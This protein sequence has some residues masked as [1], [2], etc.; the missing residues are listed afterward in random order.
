MEDQPTNAETPSDKP[1]ENPAPSSEPQKVENQEQKP[2]SEEEKKKEDLRKK[3]MELAVKF[4]EK[5]LEKY[6]DF[7][8]SVVVFGSLIRGDFHDK[9]DID[10]LVIIDDTVA[11]FSPEVKMQFDED[12]F[13]IGKELSELI[14]V[15]PAWTLTEFWDMARIGHPLLYTIVRDG[16]ALHDT[17]FWIPVRKLLE[18]GKIPSTIEAIEKLMESA[19]VRISKVETT[20]LYLIAEDLYYALLNS[21][22]GVLMYMGVNAPSPK[23]TSMAMKEHLV[24][25][26]LLE[27]EY[28]D[29]LNDVIDFRKKTEHKEINEIKGEEVDVFIEKA[30]KFLSRMD[31]LLTHIQKKRKEDMI[32]KNYEILLKGMIACLK[33]LGIN[34]DDPKELPAQIK[35]ELI[36]SGKINAL[37]E[38]ILKNSIT[39]KKMVVDGKLDEIPQKDVEITAEYIRRFLRD[40][41]PIVGADDVLKENIKNNEDDK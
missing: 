10:M 14:N 28:M 19:P 21:A 17:G 6:K 39:M 13:K 11:R 34:T 18:L 9:S 12:L 24:D 37:Y 8:K 16:W 27:K 3:N 2:I 36:E 41:T 31:Q 25:T 30:K 15:Q 32:N 29:Q 20:K 1:I 5:T 38:E 4:S 26:G 23:F 33:K 7:V 22:Q 35:K 40:I